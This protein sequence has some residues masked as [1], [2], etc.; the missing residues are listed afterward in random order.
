MVDVAALLKDSII[1]S[2]VN[3]TAQLCL[4]TYINYETI[5]ETAQKI[6][7]QHFVGII[8]L[9]AFFQNRAAGVQE[10][11]KGTPNGPPSAV[12]RHFSGLKTGLKPIAVVVVQ[13]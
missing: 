7:N 13:S 2:K 9:I 10:P 5:S 12:F 3:R 4:D 6:G 11:A 8:Y 1:L